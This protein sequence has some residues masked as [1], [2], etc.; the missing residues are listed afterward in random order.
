[1]ECVGDPR[2]FKQRR[3]EEGLGCRN[4]EKALEIRIFCK[5][6]LTGSLSEKLDSPGFWRSALDGPFIFCFGLPI[7]LFEEE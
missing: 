3:G 6:L 7:P 2:F 5:N 4:R 1:M